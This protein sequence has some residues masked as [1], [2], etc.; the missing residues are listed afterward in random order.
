M[1]QKTILCYGDSNTWGYVPNPGAYPVIRYARDQRWTGI[2]Q[3]LLGDQYYVIEEG[4]NSRT[5]NVDYHVP[6]DRNGKT[7]LPPCLYSHAPIDLVI[8]ALGANDFKV[9][10]NREASA[11]RDGLSEL[12]TIIQASTYG[13]AMQEAPKVLIM[14]PPTPL[15]VLETFKDE[16]GIA[17][18]QGAINKSANLVPLYAAL[19]EERGCAFLDI[20]KDIISSTVDGGHL[21]V[22]M[23]KKL[24]EMMC[25]KI[26]HIL[27]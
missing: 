9:Y 24:A 25:D 19:A 27:S 20:S 6:P 4:L 16:N 8:L 23:H 26:H 21:D 13:K 3:T 11:I 12:V 2:L 15:P 17:F 14:T 1:T 5:T 10:F 18:F 7:Y 22:E